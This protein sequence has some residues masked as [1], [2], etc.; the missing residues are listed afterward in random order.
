MFKKILFFMFILSSSCFALNFENNKIIFSTSQFH[1]S[2]EGNVAIGATS[3]FSPY[4][5][6][7][8]GI[9]NT[10]YTSP[11]LFF[12][13]S[14]DTQPLTNIMNFQHDNEVINFDCYYSDAWRSSDA[15]SNF[16]IYKYQDKLSIKYSG[17]IAAGATT[18]LSDG[19]VLS[20][21]GLVGIGTASPTAKL[22][23]NGTA[24]NATGTWGTYSDRRM[25]KD[26]KNLS[27]SLALVE[28]LQGVSFHWKDKEEDKKYGLMRGFIAQDVQK[29]IPEWVKTGND[30]FLVI[31]KVGVE[32]ILVEAI[33]ELKEKNDML[34]RRI[35]NLENKLE[36][37]G[38]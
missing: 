35:Y 33:K 36:K 28:K 20:S 22:Q 2:S 38:K 32:A 24:G 5:L 29:V 23:V 9:D 30:G 31:D 10:I 3:T 37:K 6:S 17:G 4:K 1:V 21:A 15:G 14:A 12:Y 11:S 34:E 8:Y 19:I 26:I 27:G 7:L 25:K 18:T 16:Q 13:T